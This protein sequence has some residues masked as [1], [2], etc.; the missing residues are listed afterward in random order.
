M[1]SSS[2]PTISVV[3]PVFNTVRYLEAAVTSIRRQSFSDF[4]FLIYDDG[5][6]DGSIDILKKHAAVDPRLHLNLGQHRGLCAW[7][8]EG[9][10]AALGRYVARMDS[11]DVSHPDRFAQQV[12]FLDSRPQCAA[13]GTTPIAI[14]EDG[15]E[16]FTYTVETAHSRIVEGLLAGRGSMLCHPTVMM[17]T[18]RVREMGGYRDRFEC[19]EDMDLFLRLSEKSE[20]ANI[21]IPLFWYRL[22]AKS[23]SNA[24]HKQQTSNI[25]QILEEACGRRGISVPDRILNIAA[26]GGVEMTA[27]QLRRSMIWQALQGG[28]RQVARKHLRRLETREFGDKWLFCEAWAGSRATRLL[29]S[30]YGV[31][32]RRHPQA[33]ASS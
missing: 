7:L 20:L 3:M 16:L 10:E 22:H 17:R 24:R 15:D 23:V 29:K 33:A 31:F 2:A 5:S 28:H 21:S 1:S 27:D 19:T 13:V 18:E 32:R 26:Q 6:T 14:D 25:A 9:T 30:A 8:N 12:A 4:E 11:D